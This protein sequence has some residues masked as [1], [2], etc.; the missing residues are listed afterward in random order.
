MNFK[1]LLS[2]TASLLTL[3]VAAFGQ[4]APSAAPAVININAGHG[5]DLSAMDTSVAP[6]ADFYQYANGKWLA[7]HPIPADHASFGGFDEA[8]DR[9]QIVL[10]S[11]AEQAA[12]DKT[13]A[14]DSVQGKVGAFYR[15]GMDEARI[16]KQGA[17]PLAPELARIAAIKDVPGLQAEIAHLHRIGVGAGWG[18]GVGQDEKNSTREIAQLGQGGLG[19]PDRDYYVSTE[20]SSQAI[21]AAYVPHIARML[22]LLGD[23]PAVAATEAQ[24]I[25]AFETRLA[26]ASKSDVDLRDPQANY[27]KMT[28]AGLNA[29]TPGVTWQPYFTGIGLPL[30]GGIDVGQPAF[31]TEAARMMTTTPLPAWK[32]YL[33]WQL[34]HADARFLSAP[35]ADENFALFAHTLYGA[36]AQRPRWQRV[37]G[38]VNAEIGEALGQL[39][40]QKAF[41]PQAKAR[42]LELVHNLQSALRDDIASLTWMSAPTKVEAL[43]KL[44]GLT[45]KIGYPDK[46]RDYSRLQLASPDYVLNVHAANAFEFQ[47]ELNKIGKPVDRSEWGMS[48]PDIDAYYSPLMN[49]IVFPAGILQPPFFNPDAD[50]AVN[51]G[52]IGMVIGHEMTHGFD[53][54][55]RQF[56]SHGNLR[57]WWTPTDAANFKARAAL[58]VQQFS[59][60]VPIG[61]TH[62]NG[63]Q[64]QGENIADLGGLKIA[65]LAY[66]KSLEGKTR[67][68]D[69]DGFTPEQRFFLG[70]AQ[71]WQENQRPQALQSQLV[72]DVHSPAR[73]RVMGPISNLPEFAAAFHCPDAPTAVK[74]AVIW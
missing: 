31:F 12:A 67:P 49:E 32:T 70:F 59:A 55:G 9:T 38:T 45:I 72:S 10:R 19:L 46:W 42:A 40:V 14:T 22:T 23:K 51:Y 39:Y 61:T 63:A 20:K 48:P 27:H 54:Q 2:L 18:F 41:S 47:R 13:A 57:D 73:Y 36:Q 21:R 37:L 58:V 50:D 29:L 33:R 4:M 34:V 25:M 35:F 16:N 69:L 26:K 74:R 17:K 52:G 62:I 1:P 7:S 68:P 5:L 30:P 3:T 56:D 66:E 28:L 43:K 8:H 64:T 6:C 65:Y 53:D 11:L 24:T 71:A 15:S 60:Y 44:N